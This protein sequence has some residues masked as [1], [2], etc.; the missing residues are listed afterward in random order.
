MLAHSRSRVSCTRSS[1]RSTFSH[2]RDC[3]CAQARNRPPT[4]RTFLRLLFLVLVHRFVEPSQHFSKAIWHPLID[5]FAVH[6]A[7]SLS[8][9]CL[10]IGTELHPRFASSSPR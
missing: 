1:P 10:D 5:N 7:Q 2:K 4:L 3:E 6:Q 8:D 9:F